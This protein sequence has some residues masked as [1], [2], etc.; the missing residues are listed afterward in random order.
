MLTELRL[1]ECHTLT[2]KTFKVVAA[3]NVGRHT[4]TL[5]FTK[6]DTMRLTV[7]PWSAL[8]SYPT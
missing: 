2:D 8:G 3:S 5:C 1:R 4:Q 6:S 7:E